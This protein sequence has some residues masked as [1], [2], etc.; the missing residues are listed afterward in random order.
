[1]GFWWWSRRAEATTA[2][3]EGTD[4][5]FFFSSAALLMCAAA[6]PSLFACLLSVGRCSLQCMF[7]C[8]LIVHI[9]FGFCVRV[10]LSSHFVSSCFC[11]CVR[12]RV[13][14]C[15]VCDDD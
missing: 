3:R 5:Y 11:V 10:S 6:C 9:A 2:R 14:F 1:M 13:S 12:A 15:M 4:T 8:V 7:T